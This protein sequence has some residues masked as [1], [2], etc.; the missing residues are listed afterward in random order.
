MSTHDSPLRYPGGKAQIAP[1]V[2]DLLRINDL[3]YG[4]Y[5]EPFAGGCAIAWKLLLND[6][7]SEV[8]I[9]DIDRALY[10]FWASVLRAPDDLCELVTSAKLT[11]K[12]WERQ[13]LLHFSPRPRQLELGF[14]TL[15]LNRTNHS[16]I[17]NGGPIGGKDQTGEYDIACRFPKQALIEKIQRIGAVRDRVKLSRL[18][19]AEFLRKNRTAAPRR[20]LFNI[21]PPYYKKGQN[22]YT[23]FYKHDDHVHLA[24]FIA[25]LRRPWM[26]TYDD[27]PSIR[28]LYRGF[29]VRVNLLN[30]TA[31]VQRMGV[32]L[33]YFSPGLKVPPLQ[34]T[35]GRGRRLGERL[36]AELKFGTSDA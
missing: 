29:K 32:E 5:I 30:Y 27:T 3:F 8:W 22:L 10:A 1:F 23:N 2:I 11:V 31:H 25:K 36:G 28:M 35:P 20:S 14:S 12:E 7:V 18:D 4:T 21:D 33:A 24:Q 16:G 17:V 15:Y 9:N 6:Y 19:A 34:T 13:R 26:L